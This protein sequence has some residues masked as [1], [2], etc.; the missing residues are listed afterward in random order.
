MNRSPWMAVAVLMAGLLVA[1]CG[2]TSA[3]RGGTPKVPAKATPSSTAKPLSLSAAAEAGFKAWAEAGVLLTGGGPGG[4]PVSSMPAAERDILVIDKGLHFPG[5]QRSL[6]HGEVLQESPPGC[7]ASILHVVGA[8]QAPS[9]APAV[10]GAGKLALVVQYRGA[11]TTQAGGVKY[12]TDTATGKY[13]SGTIVLLG[14]LVALPQVAGLPSLPTTVWS[15]V[16][17]ATCSNSWVAFAGSQFPSGM[18]PG[19]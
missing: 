12:L 14:S 16:L 5:W 13:S 17:E 11:C 19:C 1:A 15:P 3:G 6:G 9:S 2:S 8:F 18:V 10:A 4:L 7:E